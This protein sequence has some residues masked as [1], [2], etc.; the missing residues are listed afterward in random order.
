M[1]DE[2]QSAST[3]AA[4][5]AEDPWEVVA[6]PAAEAGVPPAE[7]GATV[8]REGEAELREPEAEPTEGEESPPEGEEVLLFRAPMPPP[9][10]PA[11]PAVAPEPARPPVPEVVSSCQTE[12]PSI[13][14]EASGTGSPMT[15]LTR[16]A[17]FAKASRFQYFLLFV[18]FFCIKGP[19][20]FA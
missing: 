11:P 20:P 5:S 16:F 13:L 18:L 19:S 12:C 9:W 17:C 15:D 14:G 4:I 1:Q 2:S 8:H 7:E 3:R 10:P 6:P